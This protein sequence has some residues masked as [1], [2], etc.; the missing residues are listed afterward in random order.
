MSRRA[1]EITVLADKLRAF[2]DAEGWSEGRH[3]N[4]LRFYFPPQSLGIQGKY[5]VA[6]PDDSSR[7][8]M[9]AFLQ[10]TADALR[11]IYGYQS[12]GSLLE[13][14]A[15][16]STDASKVRFISRFVDLTTSAGA[17]PLFALG[18]YIAQLEKG[19]YNSVKF[20]LGGGGNTE[21]AIAQK[22]AKECQ[23][24]QTR[25]GSFVARIDVPNTVLRQGDLFGHAPIESIQVCSSM[26]S[27]LDFLNQR[28]LNESDQ[29][30]SDESLAEA[31]SLFNVDLLDSLA[32][33]IIAPSMQKIDFTLEVGS[34]L[35]MSSTGAI[36]RE[37]VQRLKEYVAFVKKHL[38]GEDGVELTGSIVEL[39]SRD[40]DGNRNYIM[41]AAEYQ[42]ERSFVSATLNNDQY[43][44]AVDAH[45]KK[46]SVTLKGNAT[47]LKTQVRMVK[48]S[49]FSV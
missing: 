7:S 28:V 17:I 15:T 45:K 41:V 46:R 33:M 36:T 29:L 10:S 42:G 30:Y 38:L 35:R 12:V 44:K 31:I 34:T 37:K 16:L 40:P 39:R 19:L 21:K 14:A 9:G 24:L 22:F 25:E 11:E 1:D 43:Q 18:E 32:K 47:R 20:K 2:L 27:A 6:L 5:S 23:F 3:A 13:R 48:V 4:G 49:E 26:F 8:G